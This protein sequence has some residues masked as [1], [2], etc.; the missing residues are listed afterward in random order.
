VHDS[1][2]NAKNVLI[3]YGKKHRA[4]D[5]AFEEV[6]LK[7]KVFVDCLRLFTKSRNRSGSLGW[8]KCKMGI[9]EEALERCHLI[10]LLDTAKVLALD[11]YHRRG[12]YAT[13]RK[14][15][16]VGTP[17][18]VEFWEFEVKLSNQS[19]TWPNLAKM[20]L[21]NELMAIRIP[22]GGII[23]YVAIHAQKYEGYAYWWNGGTLQEMFTLDNG[24][25]KNIFLRV[26]YENMLDLDFLCI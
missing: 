12:G 5:M 19:Q 26:A 8:W 22:H 23:R 17:G 18:I 7:A 9:A 21:Q 16:I 10:A 14:V 6:I 2:W 11:N 1:I 24:H 20:E 15:C 3:K 13:I 25:G 4:M